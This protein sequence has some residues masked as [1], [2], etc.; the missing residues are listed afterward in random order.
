MGRD[1]LARY[2]RVGRWRRQADEWGDSAGRT[3][4]VE[5]PVSI[6]ERVREWMGGA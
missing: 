1:G 4:T 6:R 2:G 5:R 3:R